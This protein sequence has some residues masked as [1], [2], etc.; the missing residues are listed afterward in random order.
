MI[1]NCYYST[2]NRTVVL[3]SIILRKMVKIIGYVNQNPLPPNRVGG[4]GKTK[5]TMVSI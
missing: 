2:Y 4:A 1:T 3:R 5:L